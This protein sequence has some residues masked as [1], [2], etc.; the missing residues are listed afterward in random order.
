MTQKRNTIDPTKIYRKCVETQDFDKMEDHCEAFDRACNNVCDEELAANVSVLEKVKCHKTEQEIRRII[1]GT[2]WGNPICATCKENHPDKLHPCEECLLQFYC[3]EECEEKHWEIH[4]T[5]CRNKH[6]PFD[7]LTDPY[8]PVVLGINKPYNAIMDAALSSGRAKP[9]PGQATVIIFQD[10]QQIQNWNLLK[11][12]DM[13][14]Y[15]LIMNFPLN[16]LPPS[17]QVNSPIDKTYLIGVGISR[18][19]LEDVRI[20]SYRLVFF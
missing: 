18:D 19:S 2:H 1:V 17:I 13:T 20:V 10:E 3:S 16:V 8:R 9:V 11:E 12:K 4:K 5:Q 7:R 6:A 14:S 15:A